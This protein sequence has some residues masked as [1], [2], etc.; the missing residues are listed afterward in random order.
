M[1]GA[2]LWIFMQFLSETMSPPVALVSAPSTT[3][4]LKT[5]PQM[6][7]PVLVIFGGGRP[8]SKRKAFL[9]KNPISKFKLIFTKF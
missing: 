7:V 9:E 5:I 8:F 2:I 3:P 6:V 4:S 1:L